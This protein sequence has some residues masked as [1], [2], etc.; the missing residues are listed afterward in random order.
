VIKYQ[1]FDGCL[2]LAIVILS[3]GLEE[4]GVRALYE[5]TSLREIV[6]PPA[7]RVI[8]NWAFCFCRQLT[9]VVLGKGVEEIGE[10]AFPQ[11]TFYVK[12]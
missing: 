3:E 12:S 9:I 10:Y 6:I 1:A 11:C 7:V 4:I 5:C 2:Q 8:K